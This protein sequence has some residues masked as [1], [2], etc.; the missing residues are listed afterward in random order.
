MAVY[1]QGLEALLKPMYGL[2][3]YS[4]IEDSLDCEALSSKGAEG[5]SLKLQ[6]E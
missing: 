1:V 4:S 6:Q 5:M 3:I 2:S